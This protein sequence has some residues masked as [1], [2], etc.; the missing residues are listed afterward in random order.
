MSNDIDFDELD[1]AVS[2]LIGKAEQPATQPKEMPGSQAAPPKPEAPADESTPKVAHAQIA[3]TNSAAILN[4]P[5]PQEPTSS[6]PPFT[7]PPAASLPTPTVVTHDHESV[8]EPAI[9]KPAPVVV[10]QPVLAPKPAP[11]QMPSA[12]PAVRRGGQFMD[13]VHPS[14]DMTTN[15][16][17]PRSTRPVAS[18]AQS[19][20][21]I[22][23]SVTRPVTPQ[24]VAPRPA[25]TQIERQP[26]PVSSPEVPAETKWTDSLNFL[27]RLK[28][29]TPSPAPVES[30]EPTVI[31]ASQTDPLFTPFLSDA[32]V[33]KRPLNALMTSSL[34]EPAH[35]SVPTTDTATR[36]VPSSSEAI[37]ASELP[38]E[39]SGDIVAIEA[40]EPPKTLDRPDTPPALPPE[41]TVNRPVQTPPPKQQ[42]TP[43]VR[44][45][46][47]AAAT[48][49]IP[50]QYKTKPVDE[51]MAP[52]SM[53][54][55]EEMHQPLLTA[56]KQKKGAGFWFG[57]L[58]L[59]LLVGAAIGVGV[60]YLGNGFI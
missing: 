34:D 54:D 10:P 9:A 59:L 28:K 1:R 24:P 13:V 33:E 17:G 21:S 44:Q 58:L 42:E 12:S 39:L 57:M 35:V 2:S 29:D 30:E 31:P 55:I 32:K 3:A 36:S 41:P 23:S 52:H 60:Y 16:M 15:T 49:S 27:G 47:S 11:R 38:P 26:S 5:E 4:I 50:Q 19:V 56:G 51:S 6:Q 7:T 46:L 22:P 53:F 48:L 20:T 43:S 45:A 8:S 14:S 37:V 25:S 18:S 40:S